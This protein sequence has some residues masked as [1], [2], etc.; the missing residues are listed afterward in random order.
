MTATVKK[1]SRREFKGFTLQFP[2]AEIKYWA[3]KYRLKDDAAL[4]AGKKIVA[5]NY[6]RKDL[7][8]I[9]SW[10][11]GRRAALLAKNSDAELAEA[12]RIAVHA[13]ERRTALAVLIGLN[14]VMLPMASAILTAINP[15]KYT[16]VDFRA[17]AALG[18]PDVDYYNLNFYL[19]EYLPQCQRLALNNGVDMR[20][21]DRA[22][23][24]W[25]ADN[26]IENKV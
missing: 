11:S 21:V 22:L 13:K 1:S 3:S 15:M 5:D 24:S 12:L 7:G 6:N 4:A 14:G 2:E 18:A 17:M 26:G 20:T 23:W 9:V 25:S 8:A 16:V 19:T 10:K